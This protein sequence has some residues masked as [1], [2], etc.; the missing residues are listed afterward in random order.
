M[1]RIAKVMVGGFVACMMAQVGLGASKTPL[2]PEVEANIRLR[3]QNGETV[4]VVVAQVDA[5]GVSVHA[6]GQASRQPDRP[7][8]GRTLFE[9]GSITKVFTAILYEQ[10]VEQGKIG[11]DDPIDKYLPE[12]TKTPQRGGKP[13]T[14]RTLV[15]HTSGLP[16]MPGNFKPGNPGDPYA[17]YTFEQLYACL[18]DCKLEREIGAK[19]EYSNLGMGLLGH[20]LERATGQSYEQLVIERIC[21][22]LGMPDTCMR[23]SAEQQDRFAAG[24]AGDS[25]VPHWHLPC[26]AGAGALRSTADDMAVFLAAFLG[27]RQTSLGELLARTYEPRHP[28]GDDL[29][30]AHGWHVYTRFGTEIIWHNGG[31]GGFRSWCGFR[32]DRR[33][34]VVVLSNSTHDIDD[35]GR[36]LLEPRWAIKNVREIIVPAPEVLD[37]YVGYYQLATGAVLHV[38]RDA[39]QLFAQLTGQERYPV[40]ATSPTEFFYKIVDAQLT[41][42][43]DSK[44]Q[45]SGLILHQGGDQKA[46][47]MPPDYKPP[48]VRQ[49]VSV[50]PE[51]LEACAGRYEFA[52]GAVF[53]IALRDGALFARLTGQPELPIYPESESK[54]FYQAVDAQLTFLKDENGRVTGVVLHQMGMSQRARRK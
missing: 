22:P 21:R 14:L 1:S 32:P 19:Y 30:I 38:T 41:F 34:G 52:P 39:N 36:H 11:P 16:R 40:Y 50:A 35:I 28:A 18:S 20:L 47:R 51:V 33:Q 26:L 10:L 9:V 23:L 24:H 45:V 44:G 48:V 15:M 43:S 17:D 31:T 49:A 46:K 8:D 3:I 2:P 53:D 13:V 12:G 7:V 54:F 6:F 5:S 25:A 27:L 42:Q 37:R 29:H 4:G